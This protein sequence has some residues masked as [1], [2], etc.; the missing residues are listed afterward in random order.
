[1]TTAKRRAGDRWGLVAVDLITG[2][3]QRVQIGSWECSNF[4][5]RKQAQEYANDSNKLS[6]QYS[7]GKRYE[8]RYKGNTNDNPFV[9]WA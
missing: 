2:Q 5:Y 4:P 6:E 9:I 1:M 3:E 7:W 8:V